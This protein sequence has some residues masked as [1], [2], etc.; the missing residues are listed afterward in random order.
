MNRYNQN[1]YLVDH[2]RCYLAARRFYFSEKHS[3]VL[4]FSI[5]SN[6]NQCRNNYSQMHIPQ[7]YSE[8]SQ[9]SKIGNSFQP[10]NIFGNS[11]IFR[12]RS[13]RPEVFCKHDVLRNFT[14]FTGKHLWQS[15]QKTPVAGLGPAT[16]LKK[17]LW[18]RCFPLNFTTFLR[19]LFLTEHFW[20]LL[21][22]CQ[23]E[24]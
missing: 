7:A 1:I 10:L 13:S 21:L 8:P 11:Y 24:F 18:H 9:T 4:K 12:C 14:K 3:A 20:W 16:L 6:C 5:V 19:R 23:S 17:R 15:H 22:G 2:E